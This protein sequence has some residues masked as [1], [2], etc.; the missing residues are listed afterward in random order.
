MPVGIPPASGQVKVTPE[1][2]KMTGM[3]PGP[4]GFLSKQ[5]KKMQIIEN[6]IL[7]QRT[8]RYTKNTF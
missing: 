8:T 2:K 3:P 5:K 7:A 1:R 6:G 4:I